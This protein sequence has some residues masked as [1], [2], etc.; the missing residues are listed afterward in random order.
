MKRCVSIALA[1]LLTF[2]TVPALALE[3]MDDAPT[4]AKEPATEVPVD[5]AEDSTEE[6]LP[7]V[8]S[9]EEPAE[10]G[11]L[12]PE[13]P[14]Q[15]EA[16]PAA[17]TAGELE[18]ETI[19][20]ESQAVNPDVQGD[21][22]EVEMGDFRVRVQAYWPEEPPAE[23]EALLGKTMVF[24]SDNAGSSDG[25]GTVVIDAAPLAAAGVAFDYLTY[26]V[27][28]KEGVATTASSLEVHAPQTTNGNAAMQVQLA[29]VNI[30][31]A[32]SR[33][34][35]AGMLVAGD[36]GP[37]DI[38]FQGE[39]V[40]KSS[41]G[42]AGLQ[43][44]SDVSSTL[45]VYG[46]QDSLLTATGGFGAAGI[47]GGRS[48]GE[49]VVGGMVFGGE[50]VAKA[51]GTIAAGIGSGLA[52]SDTAATDITIESGSVEAYGNGGGAGIG[53]GP[54]AE[55]D[56]SAR[57]L[58]F[59][60]G[61]ISAY[62]Y[63]DNG[64]SV[65]DRGAGIGSGQSLKGCS[66]ASGI[67][68]G[69]A[70]ITAAGG[71]TAAGIGSG[72]AS[73]LSS[74][75][76]IA[77]ADGDWVCATGG[78][79][80][81]GIGS[82]YCDEGDSVAAG[83]S[84]TDGS[85]IYAA[86]G[87]SDRRTIGGA[88]AVIGAGAGIGS[89]W[90]ES[91]NSVCNGVLVAGADVTA[92]A[93]TDS[94]GVGGA[95]GIGS[96]P[97]PSGASGVNRTDEGS[98]STL[99]ISSG[100]V[101][102]TG[103]TTA[104]EGKGP[105]TLP[106]IG[107]GSA[108]TRTVANATIAPTQG[109]CANAWK[110]ASY[111][112]NA[113]FLETS[114]EPFSINDNTLPDAYL[115]VAISPVPKLTVEGGAYGTDP[116]GTIVLTESARYTVTTNGATSGN[117]IRIGEGAAPTV[118]LDSVS[119]DLS[120]YRKPALSIPLGA[121]KV[122]L[123]LKGDNALTGGIGRPGIYKEAW[124]KNPGQE[125]KITSI[126]GDGSSEGSLTAVG[127]SGA[128]GIGGG[129][130][131]FDSI[132]AN[133]AIAG[134]TITATGGAG[135]AGIG[136]GK[137]PDGTSLAYSLEISGGT[138]VAEGVG[139][140]GA[141]AA[142]IGSGQGLESTA[143]DI[144]ISGGNVT[145]LGGK[146]GT[147]AGIGS[148]HAV[149]TS[150][151][152]DIFISGGTVNALAS[153]YAAGIGSGS[154]ATGE[155]RAENITISSGTVTATGREMFSSQARN[156]VGIGSGAG[157]TLSEAK[158]IVITGGT[159]EAIGTTGGAGIGSGYVEAGG[160]T[161]SDG[162]LIA[163][164]IVK[165]QGE[166]DG[167]VSDECSYKAPAFGPSEV[168]DTGD[169]PAIVERST[170][171]ILAYD[172]TWYTSIWTG[173]SKE[174]AEVFG[175]DKQVYPF[176]FD[177]SAYPYARITV[178][179]TVTPRLVITTLDGRPVDASEYD[180]DLSSPFPVL[181][182]KGSGSY[183]VALADG[184]AASPHRI[185]VESG[186][187]PT[188]LLDNVVIDQARIGS[189]LDC[190]QVEGD[191]TILLK[192]QN[193]LAGGIGGCG[194]SAPAK[195]SLTIKGYEEGASLEA[196]G[197]TLKAGIGSALSS[198][199]NAPLITIDGADVTAK[200]GECA[201][202]IGSSMSEASSVASYIIITDSTVEAVG[203]DTAPGIGS[204]YATAGDSRASHI[205][206]ANSDVVAT[207]GAG[208]PGI[209]SG[210]SHEG[211]SL[212]S[213]ILIAGGTVTATGGPSLR[214]GSGATEGAVIGAGA[215]IGSGWAETGSSRAA[216][217]LIAGGTVTAS[218]GADGE[219]L[220][221]GAGIGSGVA[222]GGESSISGVLVSSGTLTATGG[223]TTRA[224]AGPTTLPAIGAGTGT[225]RLADQLSIAPDEGLWANAWKGAAAE[226]AVQFV[227]NRAEAFDLAGVEDA[228]VK[229]VLSTAGTPG[230][231]TPANGGTDTLAPTGDSTALPLAVLAVCV[232][233]A[234]ALCAAAAAGIRRRMPRNR[235]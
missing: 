201:A 12:E 84:F 169:N 190:S 87:D 160:T 79:G 153:N 109:L 117:G 43:K 137:A 124:E 178:S 70:I 58:S 76:N 40:L 231:D 180:Y 101:K 73:G 60:G 44:D 5:T 72:W 183:R 167:W 97:A 233:T 100:S 234:C 212:A 142:G 52:K 92:T 89:G 141:F 62:G 127:G 170:V 24:K 80:A 54:S 16:E 98:E 138:V 207:G 110:G 123:V 53:A 184:I 188:I 6:P 211:D 147:A 172:K 209:G 136:S 31:L 22:V 171:S 106:A 134:G 151:A 133:I 163:G 144:T 21:G 185:L 122:T 78:F 56:S 218:G 208:A 195:G 156:V 37:L 93:G 9:E 20:I 15:D 111:K 39:N 168:A 164:G 152:E 175:L 140:N 173:S 28:M 50:G 99:V 94:E 174:D 119:I 213:D 75:T 11:A 186:A 200:G 103:G 18:D 61:G 189:A 193:Y 214:E 159:V 143:R 150:L 177:S 34:Q 162:L 77:V 95:P 107:A 146:N 215:G 30:S 116:D 197:S 63:S 182:I 232:A 235:R 194:V 91:G 113:P 2:T 205:R 1:L 49:S 90:A 42:C 202:G 229:A 135:A 64:T 74:A 203:G 26:N 219:G 220:G 13:A 85:E 86:G 68:I 145:A 112:D 118:V 179:P 126:E 14:V 35:A 33:R 69:E 226:S 154:S 224:D 217:I 204:G 181:A 48:D 27:S 210:Y 10:E 36:S 176:Q 81:P 157:V 66:I 7:P 4:P 108:G 196:V 198:D 155:S 29:D 55:G 8:D 125:L 128:A 71:T 130:E 41:G 57:D 96:G 129:V 114:T 46:S 105:Q 199:E 65:N 187:S 131:E 225:T 32:D 161:S 221:A 88:E 83:L 59:T 82:G 165:A 191:V 47:G 25:P 45:T 51:Y 230:G 120:S 17:A 192:G 166:T 206:M 216:D 149:E 227:E 3:P 158:G 38:G 223:T 148:G 228:Y 104:L 115:H 19:G 139:K 102:A 132:T 121:D 222:F 67:R 23:A